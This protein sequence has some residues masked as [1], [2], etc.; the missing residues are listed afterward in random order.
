MNNLTFQN[1]GNCFIIS[2]CDRKYTT[3]KKYFIGSYLALGQSRSTWFRW[4]GETINCDRIKWHPKYLCRNCMS[5]RASWWS[6]MI[7]CYL[8]LIYNN[9]WIRFGHNSEKNFWKFQISF[10]LVFHKPLLWSRRFDRTA[11]CKHL[12]SVNQRFKNFRTFTKLGFASRFI[13]R[14]SVRNLQV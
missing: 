6:R 1:S 8:D 14:T 12:F 4:Q 13:Y 7:G 9:T 11:N 10:H 2:F 3:H 5:L